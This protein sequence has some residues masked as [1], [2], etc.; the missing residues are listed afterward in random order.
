[1]GVGV[2]SL[3]TTGLSKLAGVDMILNFEIEDRNLHEL[4]RSARG[5]QF[6]FMIFGKVFNTPLNG[7]AL[8]FDN[9][10]LNLHI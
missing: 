1:L 8:T 10:V 5:M 4:Q 2:G 6:D 3:A 9:A 7:D